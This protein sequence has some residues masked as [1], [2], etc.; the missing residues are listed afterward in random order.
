[1][2][3]YIY[4]HIYT[5]TYTHKEEII[6]WSGGGGLGEEGLFISL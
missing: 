6:K 3:T 2:Y 4:T 5:Y 1:M